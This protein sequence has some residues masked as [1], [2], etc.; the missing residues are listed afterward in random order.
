MAFEVVG[1]LGKI[2]HVGNSFFRTLP[3]PTF[4]Q[5]DVRYF[6]MSQALKSFVSEIRKILPDDFVD[7]RLSN[8]EATATDVQKALNGHGEI[9][10]NRKIVDAT[11][12]GSLHAALQTCDESLRE[13]E[14]DARRILPKHVEVV[15]SCLNPNTLSEDARTED[16]ACIDAFAALNS[17]PKDTKEQQLIELYFKHVLPK[18]QR[19]ESEAKLHDSIVDTGIWCTLVFRSLCWLSLHDFHKND[20]QPKGKSEMRGSRLPVY[21]I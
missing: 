2:L 4:Y 21:I 18:V 13:R 10:R 16:K 19:T 7:P 12:L 3:N 6:N 1:M 17:A 15:L 11:Y 5:W 14:S 20:R 8:L 9:G